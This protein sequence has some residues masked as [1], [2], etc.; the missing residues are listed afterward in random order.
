MR[1]IT[2]S[3][4]YNPKLSK[5]ERYA[6]RGNKHLSAEHKAAR[7]QVWHALIDECIRRKY[8]VCTDKKRLVYCLGQFQL[9]AKYRVDL[10]FH[11]PHYNSDPA[12]FLDDT[13]DVVSRVLGLNDNRCACS[14]DYSE[15]IDKACPRFEVAISQA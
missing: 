11:R 2:F 3:F 1:L 14:V 7:M 8:R 4:P 9:K 13:V 5:N 6:G 12:N 15:D 10:M